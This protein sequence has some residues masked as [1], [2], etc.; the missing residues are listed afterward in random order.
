MENNQDNKT[1]ILNENDLT[2]YIKLFKDLDFPHK[3][4]VLG[5]AIVDFD[6]K[7]V[8]H[9]ENINNLALSNETKNILENQLSLHKFIE[10]VIALCKLKS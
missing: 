5:I 9:F 8:A 3:P 6:S 10:K 2:K 7:G 4:E 1:E